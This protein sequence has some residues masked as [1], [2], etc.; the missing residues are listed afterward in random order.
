MID[1][2]R[3]QFSILVT[4]HMMHTA[5]IQFQYYPECAVLTFTR[6]VRLQASG[7]S[8]AITEHLIGPAHCSCSRTRK[9]SSHPDSMH[10]S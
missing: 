4:I 1:L 2:R 9:M 10:T 7:V 6:Q 3:Q 8:G 5:T